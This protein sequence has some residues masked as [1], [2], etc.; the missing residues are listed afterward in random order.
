ML[1]VTGGVAAY[2]DLLL[3]DLGLERGIE[4]SAAGMGEFRTAPL[5]GLSR[6]APYLH[7]GSADTLSA[8][9][10]G[11]HGEASGARAAFLALPE[12][13]RAALLTFLSSL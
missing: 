12:S 2:T 7:D 5:W 8:A 13:Q 11:H 10:R 9:I 6:T 1:G 3:H 4:D